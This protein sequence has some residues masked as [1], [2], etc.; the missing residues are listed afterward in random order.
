[1]VETV[2]DF[3]VARAE[4]MLRQV[5]VF[6]LFL[7]CAYFNVGR[8]LNFFKSLEWRRINGVDGILQS[9]TPNEII[10]KYFS[11]GQAGLDKFGCPG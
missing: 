4:K 6:K 3:N 2:Q 8:I 11:M 9:Y 7:S 5:L 10:K 1:M